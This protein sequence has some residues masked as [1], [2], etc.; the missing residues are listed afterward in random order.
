M[1]ASITKE[2]QGGGQEEG[3]L[4]GGDAR[5]ASMSMTKGAQNHM[6]MSYVVR[7]QRVTSTIRICGCGCSSQGEDESEN[8]GS[9]AAVADEKDLTVLS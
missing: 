9:A 2:I 5:E 4:K 3:K 8:I 6:C 1:F 7:Q